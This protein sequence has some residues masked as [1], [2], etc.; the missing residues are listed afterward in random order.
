MIKVVSFL[1]YID[2]IADDQVPPAERF[3]RVDDLMVDI[4]VLKM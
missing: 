1:I 4:V 3:V 2:K